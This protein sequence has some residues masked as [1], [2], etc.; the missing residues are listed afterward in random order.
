M[1]ATYDV[2]ISHN[3]ADKPWA[4]ALADRLSEVRWND[5]LLRPWL[6]EQVLDPGNAHE[7]EL[8]TAL[9]RSRHLVIALSPESIASRWVQFEIDYFIGRDPEC[10]QVTTVVL[11]PC[12]A[13]TRLAKAVRLEWAEAT[14]DRVL[15]QIVRRVC[16]HRF[17]RLHPYRDVEEAFKRAATVASAM[18]PTPEGDRLRDALFAFDIEDPV[19]EGLA[20]QA[21]VRAGA[22]LVRFR[23]AWP[24]RSYEAYLLLGDCLANALVRSSSYRQVVRLYLEDSSPVLPAA[25]ARALSR[26]AELQPGEVDATLVLGLVARL[27]AKERAPEDE[28]TIGLLCHALGKGRETP[29]VMMLIKLLGE[30]GPVARQ[31]AAAS[32]AL[33]HLF[34]EV[35]LIT[36]KVPVS[37]ETTH[38]PAPRSLLLGEMALIARDQPEEVQQAVSRSHQELLAAYPNDY[39]GS[40]SNWAMNWR[41]ETATAPTL[42]ERGPLLGI[43]ARA[44][45]E[46]MAALAARVDARHAVCLTEPR[47]VDALFDRAGAI[48]VPEQASDTHLCRRLRSRGV[49]FAMLA[50]GDLDSLADDDYLFVDASRVI[51]WRAKVRARRLVD[52]FP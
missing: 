27:D 44:T 28:A 25:V 16:P 33:S 5:R 29:I 43:V 11:R 26:L 30:G 46:N 6:D 38:L 39:R 18:A 8:T 10:A 42:I 13:I 19:Q 49:T 24:E 52:E 3:R 34:K 20:I 36:E 1:A 2:F 40:G 37:P 51:L 23:A 14:A 4:H 45:V 50:P 41:F 9:D 32:I 22:L 47:V 35:A 7:S 15:L 17:G 48:V 31:V 12:D 21:F